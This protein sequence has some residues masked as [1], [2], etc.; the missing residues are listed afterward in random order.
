[1]SK[2]SSSKSFAGWLRQADSDLKAR[3]CIDFHDA[4][5]DERELRKYATNFPQPAEFVSW[6]AEKYDLTPLSDWNQ[7][8]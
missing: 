2:E 5:L 7:Y 3:Y 1:M 6:F 8:R 4:G